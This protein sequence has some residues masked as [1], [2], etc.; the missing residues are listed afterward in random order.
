MGFKR[1]KVAG[2]YLLAID[3]GDVYSAYVVVDYATIKPLKFGKIPNEMLRNKLQD[4]VYT[5]SIK[6]A[7][8]EIIKSYGMAVGDTVFETC[9][10]IGR[11][12][13][14]L[15]QLSVKVAYICRADEKM[16]ICHNM[17]AKDSNIRT[18]LIDL[19][20]KHDFKNGKGTAEDPDWFFG[21][22]ADMWAAYAVSVAYLRKD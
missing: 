4:L 10:W 9:M 18:A 15:E 5:Y 12:S 2:K 6:E 1:K 16:T 7:A 22:S 13:E 14:V 20:A 19:F 17:K 11:F 3:P 8:I 21:F